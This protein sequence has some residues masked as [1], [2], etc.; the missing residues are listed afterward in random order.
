MMD[1]LAGGKT[2]GHYRNQARSQDQG[3]GFF[4]AGHGPFLSE[5]P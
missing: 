5:R 1:D 4:Y 2:D 3:K